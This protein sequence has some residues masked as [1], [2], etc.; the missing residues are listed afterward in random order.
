MKGPNAAV[1]DVIDRAAWK[2]KRRMVL[3]AVLTGPPVVGGLC[4]VGGFGGDRSGWSAVLWFVL[5]MGFALAPVSGCQFATGPAVRRALMILFAGVAPLT[6][7]TLVLLGWGR[8]GVPAPLPS[9]AALVV[10]TVPGVLAAYVHAVRTDPGAR[11][12]AQ[13]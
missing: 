5:G 8:L 9:M 13:T 1:E 10:Y 6:P 7:A 12:R 11:H 2:Y 4:A 3:Q